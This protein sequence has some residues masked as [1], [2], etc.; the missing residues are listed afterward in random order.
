M[1]IT[2][3]VAQI[4]DGLKREFGDIQPSIA[5]VQQTVNALNG[6]FDGQEQR[7]RD[8]EAAVEE[9]RGRSQRREEIDHNITNVRF[10]AHRGQFVQTVTDKCAVFLARLVLGDPEA[11]A[12]CTKARADFSSGTGPTGGYLIPKEYVAELLQLVY[13]YGDYR[14]IARYVP[15]GGPEVHFPRL[16]GE[17]AVGW[18]DEGVEPPA[19]SNLPFGEVVLNAKKLMAFTHFPS[20]LDQDSMIA[21]GQVVADAFGRAIAKEEDNQGFSGTGAPFIGLLNVAGVN[22]VRLGAA[23]SG[24]IN[25]TDF[26]PDHVLDALA[27][28]PRAGLTGA[29]LMLHRSVLNVLRKFK[30]AGSGQYAF[31]EPAGAQ[32]GMIWGVP[33]ETPEAFP[34]IAN[35]GADKALA[36]LCNPLATCM[37]GD[38][39]MV[40]IDST[41]LVGWTKDQ[42]HTRVIE[43]VSIKPGVIPAGVVVVKTATP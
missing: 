2:A 28:M 16:D 13:G 14:R 41:N 18:V 29:R 21:F 43:R 6:K 1:D 17:M 15:M 8:L 23:G 31:Q 33:W 12:Q 19:E 35:Q 11:R 39:R 34:T 25:F 37:F 22:V 9:V 5:A 32:P 20:E 26:T 42:I 10:D 38:R 24:K 3:I 36:V 40:S 30:T 7:I 27:A 4:T